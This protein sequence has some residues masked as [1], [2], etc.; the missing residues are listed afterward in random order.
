MSKNEFIKRIPEELQSKI[1]LQRFKISLNK[2]LNTKQVKLSKM[3]LEF[4]V[5]DVFNNVDLQSKERSVDYLKTSLELFLLKENNIDIDELNKKL[6]AKL[7]VITFQLI[8]ENAIKKQKQKFALKMELLKKQGVVTEIKV[9]STIGAYNAILTNVNN[10]F[11]LNYNINDLNMDVVEKYAATFENDTYINHLKSIFKRANNN[12]PNI[13]N[14]FSKLEKSVFYKFNNI[15]KVIQIY[16]YKQIKLISNDLDLERKTIFLTLLYTGM[17]L[18]ELLS[19]KKHN[20]KN[21]LFYFMDSKGYFEK[22]VPIHFSILDYINNKCKNMGNDDYLFLNN[23]QSKTRVNDIRSKI[24]KEKI[25]KDNKITLHKTRSTF[26]TYLNFHQ[27][28]FNQ[29]DITSLTHKLNKIDQEKYNK[30]ANFDRLRKI[31]N[32]INLEKLEIIENQI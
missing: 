23:I 7:N 32:S 19:L 16:T 13:I 1:G 8:L 26:I 25:F 28:N 5:K 15:N 30:V 6:D 27:E 3:V 2:C 11:D 12:N 29:N 24:H 22:I 10:H 21:N 17:R 31:I 9:D 20:I 14:Y 18:D 4:K